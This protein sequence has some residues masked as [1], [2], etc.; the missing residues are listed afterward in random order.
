MNLCMVEKMYMHMCVEYTYTVYSVIPVKY[1][2]VMQT[3]FC[4]DIGWTLFWC[5]L[6]LYDQAMLPGPPVLLCI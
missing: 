2:I 6:K 3:R 1:S 4:L 5:C